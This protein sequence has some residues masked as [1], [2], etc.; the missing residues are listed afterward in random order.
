MKKHDSVNAE[1]ARASLVLADRDHG[2]AERRAQDES[3]G[4]DHEGKAEQHEEIEVVGVGENVELEE[5]EIERLARKAAQAVVAAGYRTP[6]ERDVIKH[7][8]ERDRHH[9]KIDAAPPH[10]QG[11]ENGAA[12]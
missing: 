10:D 4:A 8:A 7:L 11:A 9:R 2:A 3:H 1:K 5:A 12:E 6:L